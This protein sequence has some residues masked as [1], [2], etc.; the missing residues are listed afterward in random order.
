MRFLSLHGFPRA[1]A[2]DFRDFLLF[3]NFTLFSSLL[4]PAVVI[5]PWQVKRFARGEDSRGPFLVPRFV[6]TS[7]CLRLSSTSYRVE[8]ALYDAATFDLAR[9]IVHSLLTVGSWKF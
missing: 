5:L 7:G 6:L 9:P 2:G 1:S 8:S 4:G 3:P